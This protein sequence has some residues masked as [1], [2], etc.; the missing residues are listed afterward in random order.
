MKDPILKRFI[1]NL[2]KGLARVESKGTGGYRAINKNGKN[3]TNALGKYQ[4]V[5][6]HHWNN[7]KKF[8]KKKHNEVLKTYDDF[9]N[10]PY[11]QEDFFEDYA[12][13]NLYPQAKKLYNS[14]KEKGL[15]IDDV[16]AM[17]HYTGNGGTKKLLKDGHYTPGKAENKNVNTSKY[18][19]VYRKGLKESGLKS[20]TPNEILTDKE[21][22]KVW[23]NYQSNKD[24][25]YYDKNLSDEVKNLKLNELNR[26]EYNKGNFDILNEK[27]NESNKILE[28]NFNKDVADLKD[29]ISLT[30]NINT[31]YAKGSKT[32]SSSHFSTTAETSKDAEK[33]NKISKKFPGLLEKDYNGFYNVD[34]EKLIKH[35]QFET[36][37]VTGKEFDLSPAI[38]GE[39]LKIEPSKVNNFFA[40][41]FNK[42]GADNLMSGTFK[43]SDKIKNSVDTTKFD[44]FVNGITLL[45]PDPSWQF[46]SNDGG[47]NPSS[48]N[49]SSSA[50]VNAKGVSNPRNRVLRNKEVL[51]PSKEELETKQTR[52]FVEDMFNEDFE[53]EDEFSY[54]KNKMKN[55]FPFAEIAS[56]L[57]GVAYGLSEA[58]KDTPRRDEEVSAAFLN[59]TAEL[60]KISEQGL[61]P[62]EESYAKRN[63]AESYQGSIDLLVRASNGNRNSVLSNLGI[64]DA[65]KQ[66]AILDLAVKD[67]DKKL[68]A[69]NQYGEAVKYI[70]Q[71][72]A[73]R[74]IANNERDYNEALQ[75]KQA[76]AELASNAIGKLLDDINHHK[77]NAPGS[78]NHMLKSHYLYKTTGIVPDIKDD[79]SG[80]QKGTYSYL[81][82]VNKESKEAYDNRFGNKEDKDKYSLLNDDQKNA[83]ADTYK[84]SNYNNEIG[85]NVLDYLSNNEVSKENLNK[86][87][88]LNNF[89]NSQEN[90]NQDFSSLFQQEEIKKEKNAFSIPNEFLNEDV[91][92]NQEEFE[93]EDEIDYSQILNQ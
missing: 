60:K 6:S 2:K 73:N 28:E 15:T 37:R 77:L 83:F 52:S 71:F 82:R 21:K 7:I 40:N 45:K 12:T 63:L 78:A 61:S 87:F 80:T 29:L 32:P 84:G 18:L 86:D 64:L 23:K 85:K 67:S 27:I 56:S 43:L 50:S 20:I 88:L 92:N 65:N 75:S 39:N 35:V 30:D 16:G 5:P 55:S 76:G 31:F 59:Y 54:D 11:L 44:P 74:D 69:L 93:G 19:E 4:F 62:E 17:I 41:A 1:E 13:K 49:A 72:D 57:A 89:K 47:D 42:I 24:Q 33:Y 66:H 79:G 90:K 3:P 48:S 9:L 51:G 14:N 38:D 70:N 25:I 53:R 58:D 10:K 91:I 8:A 34:G 81:Q 26:K 46:D 22:D 36:K 68:R